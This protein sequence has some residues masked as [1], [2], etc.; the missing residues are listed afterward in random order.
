MPTTPSVRSTGPIRQKDEKARRE[1]EQKG[2][3]RGR[4]VQGIEEDARARQVDRSVEWGERAP[5]GV[6]DVSPSP[7]N[8]RVSLHAGVKG[9][10]R[11][12]RT[13]E[14]C[15]GRIAHH[16][17]AQASGLR[18]REGV[19]PHQRDELGPGQRRLH[20][21]LRGQGPDRGDAID[22]PHVLSGPFQDRQ[23][24]GRQ[25]SLRATEPNQYNFV[26]AVGG[27]EVAIGFKSR[28]AFGKPVLHRGI[29]AH[30]Q[31]RDHGSRRQKKHPNEDRPPPG[32]EPRCTP[33]CPGRLVRH[34][35][36]HVREK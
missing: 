20:P 26:V 27:L 3:L 17:G 31:G 2:V 28:I 5:N 30:L 12:V 32:V 19:A 36:V 29:D 16:A 11:A 15:I 25:H 7:V 21:R 35:K 23:A 14:A 1:G 33:M 8:F 22:G 34:E 18:R 9:R 6:E 10:R 4:L 24:V 13:Y